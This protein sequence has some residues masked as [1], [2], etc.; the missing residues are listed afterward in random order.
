[1]GRSRLGCRHRT[2][3]TEKNIFIHHQGEV[4]PMG[5]FPLIFKEKAHER[6]FLLFGKNQ[7]TG[8][9]HA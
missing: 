4:S 1:M 3:S 8:Q 9:G 7:Q 6:H 2:D 5:S